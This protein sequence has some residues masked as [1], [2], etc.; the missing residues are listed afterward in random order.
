MK[1][2]LANLIGCLALVRCA[3]GETER[4]DIELSFKVDKE[5][6]AG[7]PI[8]VMQTITNHSNSSRTVTVGFNGVE[9]LYFNI[10][11]KEARSNQFIPRGGLSN[12]PLEIRLGPNSTVS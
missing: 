5:Q 2:L 9:H 6:I 8:F 10:E 7:A 3:N 4:P 12:S 1:S 11:G